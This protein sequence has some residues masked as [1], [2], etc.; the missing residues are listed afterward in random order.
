[1]LAPRS[2]A[3]PNNSGMEWDSA[4]GQAIL[5]APVAGVELL[6][7]TPL[8]HGKPALKTTAPKPGPRKA[9]HRPTRID[10]CATI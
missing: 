9:D 2:L 3:L 1:M 4:D 5:E 6:N 8:R 10:F 7:V